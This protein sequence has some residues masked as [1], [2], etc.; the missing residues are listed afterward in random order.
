MKLFPI[1]C[2]RGGRKVMGKPLERYRAM[3]LATP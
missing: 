3:P 2:T 1:F